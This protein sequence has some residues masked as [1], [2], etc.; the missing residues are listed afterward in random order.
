MQALHE[1]RAA[2]A[3]FAAA[4]VAAQ[5][6]QQADPASSAQ[7][8]EDRQDSSAAQH[9]EGRG[10][11]TSSPAPMP[12]QAAG[13]QT[14]TGAPESPT[15]HKSAESIVAKEPVKAASKAGAKGRLADVADGG[16][17]AELAPEEV[18]FAGHS[19]DAFAGKHHTIFA[20]VISTCLGI[21]CGMMLHW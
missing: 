2:P 16:D 12:Q 3:V 15:V 9:A 17:D 7:Q 4:P 18:G 19:D 1:S 14:P 13:S 11:P 8:T 10:K 21:F 6:A 20:G 5:Q